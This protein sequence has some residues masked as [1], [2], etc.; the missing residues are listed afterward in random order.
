MALSN[1]ERHA[2]KYATKCVGL[3]GKAGQRVLVTLQFKSMQYAVDDREIDTGGAVVDTQF[4]NDHSLA[5]IFVLEEEFPFQSCA[6]MNII[7]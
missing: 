7:H 2:V 4:F 6:N 1:D 5:V 3:F